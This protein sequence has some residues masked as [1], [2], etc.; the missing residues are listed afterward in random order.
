VRLEIL[1]KFTKSNDLIGN[2]TRDLPAC[3]SAST[4]YATACPNDD[5]DDDDDLPTITGK[6]IDHIP[7]DI[8]YQGSDKILLEISV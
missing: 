5:D 7:P 3:N 2:R 6:L 8:V 1:G 4:N